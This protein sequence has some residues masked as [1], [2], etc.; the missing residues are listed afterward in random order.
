MHRKEDNV[1]KAEIGVMEPQV[2]DCWQP[3]DAVRGKEQIL[4]SRQNEALLT[5]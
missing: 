3:S 5:P 4:I 1:I 2:K